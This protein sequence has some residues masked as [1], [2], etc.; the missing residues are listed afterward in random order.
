MNPYELVLKNMS[1]RVVAFGT[2]DSKTLENKKQPLPMF[3]KIKSDKA[4]QRKA[5]AKSYINAIQKQIIRNHTIK[6]MPI[7]WNL[8]A[9]DE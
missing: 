4:V 5:A 3:K 7:L 2:S 8:Q 6:A 1:F 9:R